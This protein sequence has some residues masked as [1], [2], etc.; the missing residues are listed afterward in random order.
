MKT[1]LK[2]KAGGGAA[3]TFVAEGR[4]Q[5]RFAYPGRKDLLVDVVVSG[6]AVEER[7]EIDLD[8]PKGTPAGPTGPGGKISR[9]DYQT[10]SLA[11]LAVDP[12]SA[13]VFVDGHPMGPASRFAEQDM[14]FKD[15]GVY[16]VVLTAPGYQ[17]RNVRVV[18]SLS[19][20]KERVVIRERL[21]RN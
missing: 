14:L 17:S 11:R 6:N 12:P 1:P 20:G 16:E 21:R 9:P 5:L 2:R 15:Q 4:H 3:L 7:V 13:S 18:V 8:L 19:T 10:V